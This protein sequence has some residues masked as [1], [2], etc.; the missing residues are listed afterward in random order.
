MDTGQNMPINLPPI[1][2]A[3]GNNTM[4]PTNQSQ[5]VVANQPMSFAASGSS[6]QDTDGA[7]IQVSAPQSANDVD[8]IEKEWVHKVKEIIIK[9]ND[10]PYE[11]SKQLTLLKADYMQKRYNKSIKLN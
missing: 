6:S 5:A 1:E 3:G 2:Q 8:L 11:Q 7:T 4:Q 9:T 10:D